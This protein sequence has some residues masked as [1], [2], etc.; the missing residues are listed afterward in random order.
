VDALAADVADLPIAVLVNN[1]GFGYAGR[2]DKQDEERLRQMIELN[3]VAPVL[4][5]RRLLPGM[6]ERGRGA[7]IVTGSVAGRQPLPLH[8][9][10]AATKAFD[11]LFGEA[12]HVELADHGIDVL[13]LEPGTTATEFQEVA[14]EIAHEGE[15]PQ[16][17]V[18]VALE[19]LG[20]QPSVVSGWGNWLGANVA[21]L[22]PRSFVAFMARDVIEKHTPEEMR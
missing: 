5:T 18:R 1:A 15:P 7:V 14:G 19:A 6:Q 16:D 13:V 21:R 12:L 17:V 11:L 2:F 20:R 3:C 10:Y 4:L 8:G 22:T 9:V